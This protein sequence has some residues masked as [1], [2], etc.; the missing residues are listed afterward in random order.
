[1]YLYL[2]FIWIQ[3][4]EFF[5]IYIF[6]NWTHI[7]IDHINLKFC[8]YIAFDGQSHCTHSLKSL[9]SDEVTLSD[10]INNRMKCAPLLLSLGSPVGEKWWARVLASHILLRCAV[11]GAVSTSHYTYFHSWARSCL[12][13]CLLWYKC[14]KYITFPSEM[15]NMWM[16]LVL[17]SFQMDVFTYGLM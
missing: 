10:S 8:R 12:L 17:F 11:Q 16:L 5:N 7:F 2:F 13:D 14:I 4:L 6:F 1:M 15:A 3:P 9:S